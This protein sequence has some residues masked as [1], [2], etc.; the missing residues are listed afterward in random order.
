MAEFIPD[1][2]EAAERVLGAAR[3]GD[4]AYVEG[5]VGSG[6]NALVERLRGEA[7]AVVIDLLPLDQ[8]DAPAVAFVELCGNLPVDVRPVRGHGGEADLRA[9]ALRASELLRDGKR[10][11]VLRV[12]DSWK[13]VER[14]AFGEN[15]VPSRAAA[16]LNGVF[17]GG[18]GVVLVSDAAISAERLGFYPHVRILLPTHL[19][20]L[21]T[22]GAFGWGT[23]QEAFDRLVRSTKRPHTAS[24]LAWRLAVGATALGANDETIGAALGSTLAIPEVARVLRDRVRESPA[25]VEAVARFLAVRRPLNAEAVA[26]VTGAE[27]DLLPLLTM[28]IGYGGTTVRVTPLV[29]TILQRELPISSVQLASTHAALAAHYKA[30][31]GA[32]SPSKL[33]PPRTSAW[34]EKVHHLGHA[35]RDSSKSWAEQDLPSP[36]FYWDRGRRLSI[37]ESDFRNAAEVYRRCAERFPDDDYA[38]HYFAWN[39]HRARGATGEVEAGYRRA[40]KLAPENPWWNAR[41]VTLLAATGKAKESRA[42][43][44]EAVQRVDPEGEEVRHGPWLSLNFHFLV[45]REWLRAGRA[46]WAAEVVRLVPLAQ[47]KTGPWRFFQRRIA[48]ADRRLIEYLGSLEHRGTD[49]AQAQAARR[50]WSWLKSIAGDELPL[51]MAE[52]TA[53]GERFQFAWSY[54]TL[55]LEVEVLPD[56]SVYWFAKDRA[57]GSSADGSGSVGEAN[58][59]L[60]GWARRTLEA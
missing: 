59:A 32:V 15:A 30:A 51:P 37:G 14:A 19:V 48:D 50:C 39:L 35:G 8:A 29:R 3:K 21:E 7:D 57:D 23:Y 2:A 31:D 33:D 40:V 46:A 58:E 43:W 24:P 10:V 20:E 9:A 36:E 13:G 28:C 47:R 17:A 54:S 1:V 53:D 42:E 56:G 60:R 55:L 26:L 25:I 5:P 4:A 6:R 22:L 38:W 49:A 11:L 45:C 34:C 41:L 44:K 18:A 27:P 12:P 52:L 16:L